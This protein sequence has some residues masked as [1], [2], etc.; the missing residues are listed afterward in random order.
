MQ[1]IIYF[2]KQKSWQYKKF[3]YRQKKI[4][5]NQRNYLYKD[6]Y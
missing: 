6:T 1:R 5:K 4:K 2:I 3:K